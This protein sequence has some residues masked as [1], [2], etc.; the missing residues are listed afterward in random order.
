MTQAFLND[1]TQVFYVVH[2]N[3]VAVTPRFT[4]QQA[5]EAAKQ[6]LPENQRFLAEVISVTGEGLQILFG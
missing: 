1:N 2:V 6:N 4:T 5:A 3:G